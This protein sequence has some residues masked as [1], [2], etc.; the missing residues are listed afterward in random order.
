MVNQKKIKQLE[1]YLQ[2]LNQAKNFLIVGYTSI[3]H[4][5]LENLRKDLKKTNAQFKVI[6]NTIFQKAINK[7]LQKNPLFQQVKK[8]FFPL[9]ENSAFVIFSQDYLSGLKLLYNQAKTN[10]QL[11]FKFGV[12][13]NTLY[14]NRQLQ[15]I[16]QLPS[17]NELL[18]TILNTLKTPIY[19]ISLASKYN[20]MKLAFIFRQKSK[21]G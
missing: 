3:S 5:A 7:V 1:S 13:E 15:R 2:L 6:K 20:L 21:Q 14:N 9:K 18:A 17:R 19:K 8:Q 12:L 11:I 16:S 4:Q 10:N